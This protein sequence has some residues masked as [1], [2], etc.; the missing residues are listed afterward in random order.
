MKTTKITSR[1]RRKRRAQEHIKRLG[2]EKGQSRLNISKSLQHIS[3]QIIAPTGGKI[4]ASAS[5]ME[6][7]VRDGAQSK[8]KMDV[9]KLVGSLI[10]KRALEQKIDAIAVD[11]NG[12]RYH[13][14]IAALVDAAREAGLKV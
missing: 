5:S 10:A 11:R 7:S 1:L 14:R 2:I 12:F 8:S 13:G 9:A 4:L 3:V 6:K